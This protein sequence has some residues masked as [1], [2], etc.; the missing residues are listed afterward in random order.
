MIQCI[1]RFP[2]DFLL[3]LGLSACIIIDRWLCTNHNFYKVLPHN[4]DYVVFF[5]LNYK[6]QVFNFTAV[7]STSGHDI[8]SGSVDTTVSQDIR[9]L[10]NILFDAVK[11]PS[12]QFPQIVRKHL[13]RLHSSVLAQLLHRC[14][15]IAAVQRFTRSG[16]KNSSSYNSA[17][18]R[19]VQQNILQFTRNEDRS[20][21][22]F[23]VHRDLA[24]PHCFHGKI[25]QFGYTDAST[26]DRLEYKIQL[27][28]FLGRFQ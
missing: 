21:F 19:I 25:P 28:I 17:P 24:I 26:A 12:E 18:L 4:A 14:P 5:F 2:V 1:L 9:Q 27:L 11:S 13:G 6:S 7:L 16:N 10:G 3:I 8:D 20:G 15:D 23:A 22:T